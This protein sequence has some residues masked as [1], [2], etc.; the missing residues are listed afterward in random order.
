MNADF[1]TCANC[2]RA[3]NGTICGW[4][5]VDGDH[6]TVLTPQRTRAS[7]GKLKLF[8]LVGTLALIALP[9]ILSR[10]ALLDEE[11]VKT[12]LYIAAG[13]VIAIVVMKFFVNSSDE[14]L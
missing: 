8:V 11:A 9:E 1:Y 2:G 10:L 12:G 5:D 3:I 13:V 6:E 4:C 14:R 7:I